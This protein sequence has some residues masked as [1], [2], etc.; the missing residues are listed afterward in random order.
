[1]NRPV[2][3]TWFPALVLLPLLFS[4]A[5]SMAATAVVPT[6]DGQVLET[7]AS[8]TVRSRPPVPAGT[9]VVAT[10][11]LL[12]QVRAEIAQAR[13]SGDTRH[14]GRAQAMLAPWWDRPAAPVDIAVLQ[15]TVQQGRHAFDAAHA[16]LRGVVAR[17]P[18]HAQAWLDLA[19]LERLRADYP[20][21][22]HAC[23]GVARAGAEPYAAACRLEIMSLQGRHDV[24]T[25]GLRALA[26]DSRAPAQRGWLLSLHAEAL[27]RAGRDALALSAYRASLQA[28][29]DLYTSIAL[30][31][32]LLR[33]G[34]AAQALVVLAPVAATDAVVLRRATALRRLGD[35][36]WL[37]LRATLQSRAAELARR[38]DDPD[39]HG[40]EAALVALWLQ[41]DAPR[42]LQ[43]AR[44]NLQLQREPVDWWVALHSA[45]RAG[46]A[47]AWTEL[48]HQRK[49]TGLHDRR[50]DRTPQELLASGGKP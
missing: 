2:A 36:R 34:D 29:A 3:N 32:L 12:R 46:D 8:P 22:L 47:A 23:D 35:T 20:A 18:A 11:E 17:A 27:E 7:L 48:Q 45:A 9:L 33:A 26:R 14:W 49:A 1:M 37:E 24:A 39:L 15:A 6:H 50:L 40:R 44:R 5:G 28:A 30:S 25:A 16:L 41:D 19:A 10:P 43:S 4:H 21:A 38:G 31:D 42:A 13:Q